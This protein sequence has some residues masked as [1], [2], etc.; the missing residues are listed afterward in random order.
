LLIWSLKDSRVGSSKQ[1]ESSAKALG[2]D[3]VLAKNVVYNWLMGIPNAIRPLGF[4]VDFKKSDKLILREDSDEAV[5]DIVIFAGRRLAGLAIYLK[6]Y[7]LSA[8]G[9]RV[10]LLAILNPNCSFKHF[11]F[12]ILPKHDG[13]KK[14]KYNNIIRVNGSLCDAS[15]E[16]P[17]STEDY[18]NRKIGAAGGPFFSLLVGGDSR[19]RK[20][21]LKKFG[22]V[23][24]KISDYVDSVNGALLISASRRTSSECM[25][26]I[27]EN[28]SCRNYAYE[29]DAR[30]D[31]PNP[32]Y[33]FIKKSAMV[34]L[35]GDSISMMSEVA[36]KNKP[37]YAYMPAE[38]LRRKHVEFCNYLVDVGIARIIDEGTSKI[39]NFES[40]GV[41]DELDRISKF[42]KANLQ[43]LC[44]SSIDF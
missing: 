1:A 28:I 35:T 43:K 21:E 20:I 15:A 13:I 36:S 9:K 2:G 29:W 12:V 40:A 3:K 11:D 31:A 7:F 19:G 44:Y 32:Y 6:K 4:G 26:K 42:I 18:W 10:V 23:V 17:N 8:F 39:E 38:L 22:L 41:L 34:F 27:K 14:D 24:K 33:F 25:D 16:A 37:I 30:N 5:P